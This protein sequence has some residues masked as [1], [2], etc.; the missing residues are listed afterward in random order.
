MR[1]SWTPFLLAGLMTP[2]ALVAQVS[3]G[4]LAPLQPA[5][6]QPVLAY[7]GRLLEAALPVTGARTFVFTLL[8]ATGA[9]LWT[10][11]S[12]SISVTSGLYS[13]ALGAAPMPVIPSTVLG[14]P[15]LK[16]HVTVGGV[17]LAPDT[18][19]VPALQARSAFEVSGAFAGDVGGTQNAMT[20]LQLQGIPLDLTTTAPVTG[21][22][23]LYN[24]AKWVPGSV[25]GAQGPAG[26]AGPVG[27]TGP[28]GLAGPAGA[29]G[30]PGA[31]GATG[32]AG[33]AGATGPQGPAGPTL[34]L[35]KVA[36]LKW[37]PASKI[38]TQVAGPIA[39]YYLCFDG[40]NLWVTSNSSTKAVT[41]IDAASG[42]QVGTYPVGGGPAGLA[43]DGGSIWVANQ[44]DNTVSRLKA[45]DGSLVGTYPVG[46]SPGA[47]CFDGTSIWV[48]NSASNNLTKLNAATGAM[49]GT[50]SVGSWPAAL[51]FDGSHLWV[52]N[53][54]QSNVSKVDPA[55]GTVVGTYGTGAY[56]YGLCF[57]GTHV[58]SADRY[59]NS[60]TK[61]LAATGAVVGTYGAGTNPAGICFDGRSI[62][63][64]NLTSND[65]TQLD[66]A[67]GAALGTHP[68]GSQPW[69]ICFDGANVWAANR[70]ADTLSKF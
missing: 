25:T 28:Q 44:S 66:A 22:G 42:I 59:G 55:T 3:P 45:S 17:A 69:G 65:V 26:P 37:Y 2:P 53:Y 35:K 58:W 13:A 19:L 46:T 43:Y 24:G 1:P 8:D 52:A 49:L 33:P 4:Q 36:L 41:K 57:D 32:A 50:F 7:Q 9:E 67:T 47:V 11:G 27:P 34:N 48:A 54:Q 14:Q 39:P 64:T 18:D 62:W 12:Q 16:L 23:L 10:S 21:Q 68:A 40:A 60:V 63:V 70:L 51:C 6:P 61:I 20:L 31:P 38:G 29:V 5:A 56:P 30:A 15:G